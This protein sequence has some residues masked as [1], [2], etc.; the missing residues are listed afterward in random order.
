MVLVLLA[1]FGRNPHGAREMLT[2]VLPHALGTALFS[3]IVFHIAGKLHQATGSASARRGHRRHEPASRTDVAEFRRRPRWLA[4]ATVLGFLI[5][6]V[7]LFVLQIVDADKYK[8]LAR[9]NII[10]RPRWRRRAV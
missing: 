5:V 4:L 3:P 9:E 2:L 8:A 10:R 1:I 6:T 7:R